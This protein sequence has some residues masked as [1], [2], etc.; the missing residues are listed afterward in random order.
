[1]TA[2]DRFN[3]C[4]RSAASAS[5][6]RAWTC[7]LGHFHLSFRRHLIISSGVALTALGLAISVAFLAVAA[8]DSRNQ[9]ATSSFTKEIS[10]SALSAEVSSAFIEEVSLQL[11][12]GE[13]PSR[14]APLVFVPAVPPGSR[15][16]VQG[17]GTFIARGMVKDVNITF[18]DCAGQGFCGNM[19][20]GR[21]VYEGAAACSWNLSIGTEFLILGDPTRRIYVCEDRGLLNDTWVDV[22][23]HKPADGYRWQSIVGRY[24]SIILVE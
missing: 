6:V 7:C 14:P 2:I 5:L 13:E 10:P 16:Q 23:W 1:M 20:N 24:G 8:A 3:R 15:I 17:R 18:Y 9:P 11:T 12:A 22:F 4:L 21:K 19:Y